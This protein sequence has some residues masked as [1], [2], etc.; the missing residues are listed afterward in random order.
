MKRIFTTG[1]VIIS[2]PEYVVLRQAGKVNLGIDN[3]V[4]TKAIAAG[5]GPA[6]GGS[7]AAFH[8]YSWLAI[9]V[10]IVSI[11]FSL[12]SAWWWFIPGLIGMSVIWSANKSGNA[13]NLLD[14]AMYDEEFYERFRSAGIW[15]YEMAEE[16]AQKYA[17]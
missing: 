12:T 2:H 8:F 4:A 3:E 9:G 1:E 14:A 7:A 5:A 6:K 11:Y 15:Q 10:F 17:T 16:D 13:G